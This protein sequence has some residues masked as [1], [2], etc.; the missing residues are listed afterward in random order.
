[1]STLAQEPILTPEQKLWRAVLGQAYADAEM[2]PASA[3]K[4]ELQQ[5]IRA[6]KF[7]RAAN[8]LEAAG[9]RA[10]C[11]FADVPF[12][13]VVL[14]ARKRYPDETSP[15]EAI[16]SLEMPDEFDAQILECEWLV[17]AFQVP[18]QGTIH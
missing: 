14:W 16:A 17:F 6:R 10:I 13:R 1:M 12:D 2:P 9:L 4:F 8:T 15:N 7:L 18:P 11:G 3:S 5:Q